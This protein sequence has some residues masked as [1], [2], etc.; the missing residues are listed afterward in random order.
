VEAGTPVTV[1]VGDEAET[2]TFEIVAEGDVDAERLPIRDRL[3]AFGGRLT[4]EGSDDQTRAVG[5]LPLP[6]G[7]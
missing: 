6:G 3:E 4:I 1:R 5:S 7:G 2:L